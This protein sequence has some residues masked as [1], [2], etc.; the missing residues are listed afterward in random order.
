MAAFSRAGS[1]AGSDVSNGDTPI[2]EG[3]VPTSERTGARQRIDRDDP[4]PLYRQ[5]EQIVRTEIAAGV[6]HSDDPL[7]SEHELCARYDVSRSVVRQ[8]LTNLAHDGVIRTE[9]GR[10]SF[11]AEPKLHE[12]FVQRTTGFFDDLTRRGLTIET[13]VLRQEL[14]EVPMEVADFLGVDRAIRIDRLRWVD[15]RLVTYVV[16][17]LSPQ[18]CP[19]LEQHD[20]EN[21]SLYAHLRKV[22]NLAVEGGTRTVEAVAAEGEVAAN[23]EVAEGEPLLLLRSAGRTGDGEP[24]EWFEAW[25]RA[26]RTTFE[27]ELVPG[28]HQPRLERRVLDVPSSQGE[29]IQEM[30]D[31]WASSRLAT[32][33]AETPLLAVARA[34][35]YGDGRRIASAL[36]DGGVRVVEF[37]LSGSGAIEAIER[38]RA[39]ERVV[40]GAGSI[41][42]AASARRALDAGAE[43]LACG[44]NVLEAT[45]VGEVPVLLSGLTPNELVTAWQRTGVPVKLFP[46]SMVGPERLRAILEAMPWLPVVPASGVDATDAAAYLKSGA[47]AVALDEVICPPHALARADVATLTHGARTV[48]AALGR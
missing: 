48:L 43:F 13:R 20:L 10:G 3:P 25:H 34:P 17:Y 39:D 19:G 8:A 7:P 32:A 27:V 44:A 21:R 26:D 18:R 40:V 28:E 47:A 41:T 14:N 37:S 16:T 33:L 45:A 31:G 12:K 2:P 35:S 22:Y 1:P 6:Y 4:T 29:R 30:A 42:D 38:A 5:V 9:R 46:A 36:A 24:L 23:L 11:V 15:G